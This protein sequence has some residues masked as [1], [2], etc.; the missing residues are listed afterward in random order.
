MADPDP[1]FTARISVTSAPFGDDPPYAVDFYT[2]IGK[3]VLLWGRLERQLDAL[4][5]MAIN[6]AARSGIQEQMPHQLRRRLTLL[7]RLYCDCGELSHYKDAASNLLRDIRET[8]EERHMVIHSN[9]GGF[10]HGPPPR[11][12]LTHQKYK[13]DKVLIYRPKP[14]LVELNQLAANIDGLNTQLLGLTFDA[15]HRQDGPE[16]ASKDRSP[17]Q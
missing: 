11:L 1:P 14:T 16:T 9:W 13:G 7:E 15:M 12:V 6:I 4:L 2:T 17:A 8:S 10:E 5:S 3:I